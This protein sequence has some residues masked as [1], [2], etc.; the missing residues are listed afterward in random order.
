MFLVTRFTGK[1]GEVSDYK[2]EF[3]T[4]IAKDTVDAVVQSFTIQ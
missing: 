2:L 4:D 3:S 1:P